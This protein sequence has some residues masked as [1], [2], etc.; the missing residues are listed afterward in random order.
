MNIQLI[1]GAKSRSAMLKNGG[2]FFG[3]F[4]QLD[5]TQFWFVEPIIFG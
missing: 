4:G 2:K 3:K 1:S 5:F